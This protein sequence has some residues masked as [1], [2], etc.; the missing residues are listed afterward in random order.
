MVR[1]E[2]VFM[3]MIFQYKILVYVS[4]QQQVTHAQISPSFNF[5]VSFFVKTA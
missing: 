4:K 1:T 2:F 5:T 3:N